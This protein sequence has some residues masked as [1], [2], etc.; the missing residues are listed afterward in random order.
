MKRIEIIPGLSLGPGSPL[1]II[2]G[3]CVVESEAL[4]LE[5][6]KMLKG[7][8]KE[9]GV[10]FVFKASFDKANRSVHGSFR[11]LGSK[12]GWK[13]SPRSKRRLG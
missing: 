6:A 10:G 9:L 12:K 11:G 7:I 5:I 2:A 1:L 3:P 4:T 13:C 8:T